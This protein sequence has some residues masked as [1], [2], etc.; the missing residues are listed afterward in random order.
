MSR[1]SKHRIHHITVNKRG[2]AGRR[3]QYDDERELF[4]EDYVVK[5][6]CNPC[7]KQVNMKPREPQPN[8]YDEERIKEFVKLAG[9][10][11]QL[12]DDMTLDARITKAKQ[13][14]TDN[15]IKT[16][17]IWGIPLPERRT[18]D[19]TGKPIPVPHKLSE[20]VPGVDELQGKASGAVELPQTAASYNPTY[21]S[22]QQVIE[23]LAK[24]YISEDKVAMKLKAIRP[25]SFTPEEVH[26]EHVNALLQ[27]IVERDKAQAQPDQQDDRVSEPNA[28]EQP[29]SPTN[30]AASRLPLTDEVRRLL[31]EHKL[32]EVH[33]TQTDRRLKRRQIREMS[34]E[35]KV[36]DDLIK[37][38]HISKLAASIDAGTFDINNLANQSIETELGRIG[39]KLPQPTDRPVPKEE[40]PVPL[41]EDCKG[42]MRLV[43]PV[44][45]VLQDR[46]VSAQRRN[47]VEIGVPNNPNKQNAT[48]E[49]KVIVH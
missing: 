48:R 15:I 49:W 3:K 36:L 1:K 9:E 11:Q 14:K 17:D 47:L 31:E 19:F 44:G 40:P 29:L 5:K 20:R 34:Q 28:F 25:S 27:Y 2:K 39:K 12:L 35:L 30:T 8:K 7:P 42:T 32:E 21:L 23:K 22:Q 41:T 26:E 6:P 33:M 38:V 10:N 46:W 43:K 4:R 37:Q 24:K 45:S 13:E 18:T 16:F